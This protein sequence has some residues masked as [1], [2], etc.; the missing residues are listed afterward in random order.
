M[1]QEVV[2]VAPD[3]TSRAAARIKPAV[4]A[5]ILLDVMDTLV[6]DPFFVEV[7]VHFGLTLDELVRLKNTE[8]WI[9][10][11]EGR[12]DEPTYLRRFFADRREFDASGMIAVIR[13]SYRW[14]DGMETLLGE[15]QDAGHEMHLLSNYP[16]WYRMIEEKLRLSRYALWT[17]VSCRTT[18]RKPAAAAFLGAASSLG[19]RVDECVFIDDRAVNC[20]AARAHGMTSLQFR[21]APSLRSELA[22]LGLLR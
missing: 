18:V 10:F 5:L 19:A 4:S 16:I 3:L 7:P 8:A 1:L 15:I 9:E 21:D 2:P 11:E 17:F 12:I 14:L 13:E 6:H 20:A 22:R